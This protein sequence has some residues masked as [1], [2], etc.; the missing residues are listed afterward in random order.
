MEIKKYENYQVLEFFLRTRRFETSQY[1]IHYSL[2]NSEC[3]KYSYK[4]YK[5]PGI[6]SYDIESQLNGEV[7]KIYELK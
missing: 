5:Q 7:S 6:P 2:V 3:K 1:V 4:L